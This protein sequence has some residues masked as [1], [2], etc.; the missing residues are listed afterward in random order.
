MF[1]VLFILVRSNFSRMV[2]C[3]IFLPHI[4]L[5]SLLLFVLDRTI[6]RSCFGCAPA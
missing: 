2:P 5:S 6:W 1:V 3:A 4:F